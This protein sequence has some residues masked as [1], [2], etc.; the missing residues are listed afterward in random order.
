VSRL[1]FLCLTILVLSTPMLRAEGK[2]LVWFGFGEAEG[3]Y[4]EDYF[5]LDDEVKGEVFEYNEYSYYP[6]K[7]LRSLIPSSKGRTASWFVHYTIFDFDLEDK[8]L[9]D[10]RI[11][12]HEISTNL[13]RGYAYEVHLADQLSWVTSADLLVGLGFIT[14]EKQISSG[15]RFDYKWG[16]DLIY[17]YALN[18]FLWF[19]EG[20]YLGWRS[21]VLNNKI[22]LE[23][24]EEQGFLTHRRN[25]LLIVGGTFSGR[26]A[27]CVPTAYVPC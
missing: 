21:I 22:T 8:L 17:G 9:R 19:D 24:G 3:K 1:C 11:A 26:E 5:S 25:I 27:S 16:G 18:S 10:H 7:N 20:L 12:L 6:R 2:G 15:E 13:S 14:F 23:Y 4:E